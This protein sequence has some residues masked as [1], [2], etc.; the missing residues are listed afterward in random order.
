MNSNDTT[1][2]DTT[3]SVHMQRL[4]EQL[5]I[6][7]YTQSTITGYSE[8]FAHFLRRHR[9]RTPASFNVQDMHRYQRFLVETKRQLPVYINLATDGSRPSSFTSGSS[10]ARTGA[11]T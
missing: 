8:N 5:T 1:R 11:G 4:R 2:Y 3:I 6:R 10:S 7:G 9:G